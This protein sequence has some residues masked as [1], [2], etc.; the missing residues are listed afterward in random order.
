MRFQ[1]NISKFQPHWTNSINLAGS[2]PTGC[3][4]I[5]AI[6]HRSWT[7]GGF[8]LAAILLEVEEGEGALPSAVAGINVN[9][10]KNPACQLPR[11]R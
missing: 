4:A 8:L 11:P 6:P 9:V 5:P 2:S 10:C 3:Q 1:A 7:S